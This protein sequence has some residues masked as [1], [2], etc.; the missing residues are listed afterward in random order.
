VKLL[1]LISQLTMLPAVLSALVALVVGIVPSLRRRVPSPGVTVL[2]LVAIVLHALQV[3]WAAFQALGMYLELD[4]F[5]WLGPAYYFESFVMAV[6]N[7]PAFFF[8][9]SRVRR[10]VQAGTTPAR[11][12]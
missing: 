9:L 2:L 12:R 11:R 4:G 5:Q 7:V 3:I 6:V 1:L 8:W 10:S